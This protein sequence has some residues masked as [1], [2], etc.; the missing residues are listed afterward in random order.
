MASNTLA[1]STLSF[2]FT[3]PRPASSSTRRSAHFTFLTTGHL[4][5]GAA[6]YVYV[7]CLIILMTAQAVLTPGMT[8]L[9]REVQI[10]SMPRSTQHQRRVR[11]ASSSKHELEA[12]SQGDDLRRAS[13]RSL[14]H[15]G[16]AHH[17]SNPTPHL[18]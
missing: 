3:S 5:L 17:G 10:L 2:K 15:I 4:L 9:M 1:L 16:A 11:T 12:E 6:Q 8:V 18:S 13:L 14:W 7:E